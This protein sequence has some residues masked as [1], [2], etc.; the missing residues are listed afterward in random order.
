[1]NNDQLNPEGTS[2]EDEIIIRFNKMLQT[3][4][5]NYFESFEIEIIIDHYIENTDKIKL[6]KA[7][8]LYEKLH[9]FSMDLKIKKAQTLLF[10]NK[11]NQALN[12]IQKLPFLYFN[13]DYLYTLATI[14]SELGKN[15]QAI[16]IFE[17]LLN[18]SD[19]K[20]DLLLCLVNEYNIVDDFSKSA[21]I[22]EKLIFL[23]RFNEAYWYSYIILCKS[24]KSFNRSIIFIKDFI[25]NNPYDYK[26]WFHLGIIYQMKDNHLDA[27]NSFEYSIHIKEDYKRAYMAKVESLTEI[28]NYQKAIECLKEILIFEKTN[29]YIYYDIANLYQK[30]NNIDSAKAYYIKCIKVDE[31][32]DKAFYKIALILDNQNL[33]EESSYFIQRAIQISE[34]NT[35]YI[36]RY[37]KI[38]EKIGLKKEAEIAYKKL[39]KI[40]KSDIE[41]WLDCSNIVYENGSIDEAIEVLKKGI[42]IHPKNTKLL[43]RLLEFLFL[44]DCENE[45]IEK[46]KNVLEIDYDLQ[47]FFSTFTKYNK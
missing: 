40:D 45:A 4:S 29:A 41:I 39:L 15:K 36:F 19:D 47:D 23:D 38:H 14:Y 17:R 24:L 35:E 33:H 42:I 28:G 3:S 30:L 25:G 12:V 21:E 18:L 8:N 32:F 7:F 43:Y 9:P 2:E 5:I 31:F 6:K 22:L 11:A 1:M 26:A 46:L 44:A 34:S 20:E 37:A 27:I 10:F 13:E 16:P